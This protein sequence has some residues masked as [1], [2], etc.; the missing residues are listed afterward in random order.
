M[1]DLRDLIDPRTTALVTQECQKGAIGTDALWPA[2]ADAARPAVANVVR[3]TNVA[4]AAGV[5]VFHCLVGKRRDLR[6]SNHN[7]PLYRAATKPGRLEIGTPATELIGELAGDD[8][9]VVLVRRHGVSPMNR[10]GLDAMLRNLGVTTIVLS[11]VSVNVAITSGTMDAVN[12][13]YRVVI[14]RDAV[15]GVPSDYAARVVDETLSLL[16]TVATS[17]DIVTVWE[18][19]SCAQSS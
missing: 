8:R 11:G 3:L 9:D 13:G 7:A 16:A 18:E 5:G 1:P 17:A 2:L 12:A 10:T 15:A 14:P 19:A 4:R 6:G